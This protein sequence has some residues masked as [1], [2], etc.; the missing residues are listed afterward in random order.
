MA[1]TYKIL[2]TL[3]VMCKI[4]F[5]YPEMVRLRSSTPYFFS[6][7]HLHHRGEELFAIFFLFNKYYLTFMEH[8]HECTGA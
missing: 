6:K 2:Y 5:Y 3:Y 1:L 8:L 4:Y 7:C